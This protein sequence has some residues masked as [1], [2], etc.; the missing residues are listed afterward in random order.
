MLLGGGGVLPREG[1]LS[2]GGCV[3]GG[4]YPSMH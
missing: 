2:G 1:V 4:W 3:S